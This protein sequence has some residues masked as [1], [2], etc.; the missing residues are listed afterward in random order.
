M[1]KIIIFILTIN[2]L[3]IGIGCQKKEN[4]QSITEKNVTYTIIEQGSYSGLIEA[5]NY[6]IF[7]NNDWQLFWYQLK[8]NQL[9]A[10]SAPQVD[11]SEEMVIAVAMG[12][13]N[14][15]GYKIEI[16]KITTTD[17]INV[18]LKETTPDPAG[19]TTQALTQPY[20]IV[21]IPLTTKEI[22]YVQEEKSRL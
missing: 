11:F 20:I 7:N 6:S 17:K 22:N 16:E 10:P 5:K 4:K 14:S 8:I 19:I 1:K 13:K 18:Y 3:L 12:E 21:K 9:A 15:G 2:L